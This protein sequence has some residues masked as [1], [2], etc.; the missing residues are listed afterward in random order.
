[1]APQSP[2]RAD[3]TDSPD[4]FFCTR[5]SAVL[6][7]IAKLDNGYYRNPS[8]TLAERA[9]YHERQ[10]A[11]EQIRLRLYA[12]LDAVRRISAKQKAREGGD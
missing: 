8:P 7:E 3:S 5:Y 9:E 4:P 6:E 1:M 2:T 10:E 11:L 12:E